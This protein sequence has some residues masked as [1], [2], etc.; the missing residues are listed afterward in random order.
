MFTEM[1][2]CIGE[3]ERE[4]ESFTLK[5]FLVGLVLNLNLD[6]TM[7]CFSKRIECPLVQF[8]MKCRQQING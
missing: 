2:E 3:G 1:F 5:K 6:F 4:R 7:S 8:K